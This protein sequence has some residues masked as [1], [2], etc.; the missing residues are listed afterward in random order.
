MASHCESIVI[1]MQ[2][3]SPLQLWEWDVIHVPVGVMAWGP[4]PFVH[5]VCLWSIAN[6]TNNT[7][8]VG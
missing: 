1:D 8:M 5:I 7:G 6:N 2:L 3:I 4:K